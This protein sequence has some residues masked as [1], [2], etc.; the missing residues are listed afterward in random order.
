MSDVK[1]K[2][3]TTAFKWHSKQEL[4]TFFDEIYGLKKIHVDK[5]INSVRSNFKLRKNQSINTVELW[6]KVGRNLEKKFG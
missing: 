4:Y 2:T 1:A 3:R 5:E 6:E